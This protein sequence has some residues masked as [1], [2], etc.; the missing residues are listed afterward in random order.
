MENAMQRDWNANSDTEISRLDHLKQ[1]YALLSELEQRLSG[2]RRLVDCSGRL[3]WPQR[4]VYFFREHGEIRSDSGSGPRIVRVGTHALKTGAKSTLWGR[5]GQHKGQVRSGAGNHR[6]SIFRLVVGTALI[7]RDGLEYP[8]WG[9]GSNAPSEVREGEKLLERRVSEV[10]GNMPVLW[11]AVEDQPGPG[12]MRGFIERNSI[13]LL[14]NHAKSAID[15]P[16]TS[17]LGHDC[18]R[19][20][21]R[22][23]GMWNTNHVDE[24]YDPSFLD[25]LAALIR[26]TGS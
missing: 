21:M 11:L 15:P 16:S 22:S 19:E 14:S 1:F 23:S 20:K 24:Q 9:R 5:L 12:S 18:N 3:S 8:T 7:K 10:I 17:W 2:A 6:G 4:G 13:S 25:A 26:Q